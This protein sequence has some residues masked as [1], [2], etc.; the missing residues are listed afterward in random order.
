MVQVEI[1]HGPGS[2]AARVKMKQGET[3]TAEGGAMIAMRG[4]FDLK[5]STHQRSRGIMGGL[6]RMIGGESFFLNQYTAQSGEGEVILSA[7]LPGDM[8]VIEIS[9][10]GLVVEGG[11]F[12]CRGDG[13]Q[14]DLSWQG[15]KSAFSGE[16]LFWLKMNGSGPL[17]LNSFG[18]IYT[19]DIDGEY[20]VDTGHILAFEETLNF[21]ISKA[22]KSWISSYLGG[23]GLVCRFK[24][25]GRIWCQ[26]HNARA[27]GEL[28]GPKL[29]PRSA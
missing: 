23:E 10:V 9:H 15:L 21:S 27:F 20:I 28:V 19:I 8:A 12:V 22:G 25:R 16:G 3:L 6:K 2:A 1:V 26:S 7:T 4:N 14:M 17:V 11:A 5:T 18:A 29:R 13:V 24:G